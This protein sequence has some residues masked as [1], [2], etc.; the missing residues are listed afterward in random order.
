MR[1]LNRVGEALAALVIITAPFWVH[2]GFWLM[3]GAKPWDAM[4]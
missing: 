3:A 4:Q 1:T 2:W